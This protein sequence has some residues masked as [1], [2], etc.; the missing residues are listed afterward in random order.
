MG[1]GVFADPAFGLMRTL[2]FGLVKVRAIM[3][4]STEVELKEG[5]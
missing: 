4:L 1:W 5:N 2:L 3:M